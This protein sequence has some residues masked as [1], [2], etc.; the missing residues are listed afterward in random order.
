M[1]WSVRTNVVVSWHVFLIIAEVVHMFPHFF[2]HSSSWAQPAENSYVQ[3]K[4]RINGGTTNVSA[5]ENALP[6]PFYFKTNS[7]SSRQCMWFLYR[8]EPLLIRLINAF[9]VIQIYFEAFTRVKTYR[10]GKFSISMKILYI[11]IIY[12]YIIYNYYKYTIY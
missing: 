5:S 11:N 6:T 8:D 12:I 1:H 7:L 4:W 9:C 2:I 10:C 3:A